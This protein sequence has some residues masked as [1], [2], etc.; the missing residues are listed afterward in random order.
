ML[1]IAFA[2]W[3][4]ALTGSWRREGWLSR[5]SSGLSEISYTLY[6]VHFPILFGVAAVLLE[7]HQFRADWVGYSWFFGLTLVT[8]AIAAGMWWAFERNT[9]K[10]RRWAESWI[11]LD[12][13]NE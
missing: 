11:G 13:S 4:L 9:A 5:I 3:M 10:V 7:G 1:G 12:R 2:V 8:L 6:V